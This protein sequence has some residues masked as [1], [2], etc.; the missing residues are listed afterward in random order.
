LSRR[1]HRQIRN[2]VAQC[3]HGAPTRPLEL[4]TTR[5][6]DEQAFPVLWHPVFPS[7]EH[8]RF[9]F[10]PALPQRRHESYEDVAVGPPSHVRH[11]LHKNRAGLKSVDHSQKRAPEGHTLVLRS[12]RAV[13]YEASKLRGARA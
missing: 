10:Q 5:G 6:N 9:G 1:N 4:E 11:V 2:G 12:S 3:D 8:S 7:S 13:R